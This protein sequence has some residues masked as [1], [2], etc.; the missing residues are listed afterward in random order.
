M[1]EPS[2][3]GLKASAGNDVKKTAIMIANNRWSLF[4]DFSLT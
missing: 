1:N 3:E 4:K 2:G